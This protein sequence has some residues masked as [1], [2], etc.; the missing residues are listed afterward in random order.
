MTKNSSAHNP[1]LAKYQPVIGLEVHCQLSTK[2]KLFCAC[3]TQ[4]IHD[5]NKNVCPVCLGHPGTL[6][7]MNQKAVDY[8]ILFALSVGAEVQKN[9]VF[10]RKQYFYPDL[11]K[12]YQITQY[13]LPYCLD[14]TLEL[15]SGKTIRIQR[16]HLEEDAGKNIHQ[17]ESSFVNLNRAGTPLI[18][19]VSHPDLE[20]ALEA[21]EYLKKLHA[22]VKHLKICDGNM[23]EGSF[24]CDANVSLKLHGAKELGTRCEIKN[25]NSFKNVERAINYEIL[26]QADLLD[27]GEKI[28]QSTMGFDATSGKTY[29]QRGK[30][31]SHDYRYFPEPDLPV[32]IISEERVLENQSKMPELPEQMAKRFKE[33]FSIS[34]YDASVLTEDSQYSEYFESICKSTEKNTKIKHKQIANMMIEEIIAPHK[35]Q[36]KISFEQLM[37]QKYFNEIIDLLEQGVVSGKISKKLF[38]SYFKTGLSPKK[39]VDQEGLSQISDPEKIKEFVLDCL[40][41][42]PDQVF[43][44]RSGKQKVKGFLVGKIM[45]QSKGKINPEMLQTVLESELK[46]D[47]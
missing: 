4:F 15:D 14:G 13:D 22:I 7:V 17:S 1:V 44:Y 10:S 25:V 28:V 32:L 2:S 26:R 41:S 6:P 23:E 43:E 11:P 8:A 30:E 34:S 27:Y 33:D 40:A 21:S 35:K 46:K 16:A 3:S 38:N 24:R 5:P 39:I 29:I 37:P 31:E 42:F 19:I 9:S 20:T 36:D 45:Q 12:G 47:S 18:E